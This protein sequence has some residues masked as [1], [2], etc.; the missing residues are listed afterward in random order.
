MRGT[1]LLQCSFSSLNLLQQMKRETVLGCVRVFFFK[2][3]FIFFTKGLSGAWHPLLPSLS[4]RLLITTS[5]LLCF[6]A[7]ETAA[8]AKLTQRAK[9]R[10]KGLP[11][12]PPSTPPPKK[13]PKLSN[14]QA[15]LVFPFKIFIFSQGKSNICACTVVK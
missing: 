14:C 8:C 5:A 7:A 13:N 10:P 12:T 1:V 3:I 11:L 15:A 4:V 2:Y 6:D 9:L